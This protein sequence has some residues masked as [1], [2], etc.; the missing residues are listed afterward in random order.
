[1]NSWLIPMLLGSMA[2]YRGFGGFNTSLY[3]CFYINDYKE[4]SKK[5]QRYGVDE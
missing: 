4:Y 5:Y 2:S 3:S 1:M